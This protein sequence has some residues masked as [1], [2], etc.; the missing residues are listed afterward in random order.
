MGSPYKVLIWGLQAMEVSWVQQVL[1]I[2][3]GL[4]EVTF[5]MERSGTLPERCGMIEKKLS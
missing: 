2:G 5:T 4:V 3:I 1:R